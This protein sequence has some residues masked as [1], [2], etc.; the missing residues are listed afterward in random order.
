MFEGFGVVCWRLLC[1]WASSCRG[2]WFSGLLLFV[3]SDLLSGG[4]GVRLGLLCRIGGCGWWV[5]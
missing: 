1:G 4:S 5:V 2:G 3:V